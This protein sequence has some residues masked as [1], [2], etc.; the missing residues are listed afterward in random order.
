MCETQKQFSDN[1]KNDQE[2]NKQAVSKCP[3][4]HDCS[5]CGMLKTAESLLNNGRTTTK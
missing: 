5:K 3:F 2:Y 4:N 1:H